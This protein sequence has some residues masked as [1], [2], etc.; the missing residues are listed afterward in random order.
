MTE[1][2]VQLPPGAE[3]SWRLN[4]ETQGDR[5]LQADTKG[6]QWLQTAEYAAA[7]GGQIWLQDPED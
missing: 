7:L 3:R 2:A 5:Q 6:S 1:G 4:A